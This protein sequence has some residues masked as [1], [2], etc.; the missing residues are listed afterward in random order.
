MASEQPYVCI[1][2]YIHIHTQ[3]AWQ[4]FQGEP[5]WA[6]PKRGI[7]TFSHNKINSRLAKVPGR[8]CLGTA[9]AWNLSLTPCDAV[10]WP[11]SEG[12]ED[13]EDEDEKVP[14]ATCLA[15]WM[16]LSLALA[17]SSCWMYACVCVYVCMK[18]NRC[19]VRP[20]WLSG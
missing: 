15:V 3:Q 7:Y 6:Q 13:E 10:S 1:C 14:C 16:R 11:S 5:A 20:A 2:V 17:I 19:P 4:K 18:M 9:K 8:A 12:K